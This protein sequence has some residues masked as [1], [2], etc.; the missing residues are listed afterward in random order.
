MSPVLNE[1]TEWMIHSMTIAG[2]KKYV[3]VRIVP[4]PTRVPY[5]VGMEILTAEINGEI[6]L[7]FDDLATAEEHI[8]KANEAL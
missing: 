7:Y 5:S 1:N 2:S 4:G 3:G 8:H 6:V